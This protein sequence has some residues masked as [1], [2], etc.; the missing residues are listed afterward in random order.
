MVPLCNYTEMERE[1]GRAGEGEEMETQNGRRNIQWI[2]MY[3]P[4]LIYKN[5]VMMTT[6]S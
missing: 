4:N 3:N 2:G 6:H 5:V 1:R